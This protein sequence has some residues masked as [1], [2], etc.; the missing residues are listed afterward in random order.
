MSVI[1]WIERDVIHRNGHYFNSRSVRGLRGYIFV[2][3]RTVSKKSRNS[4]ILSN[5][6][7]G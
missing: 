7:I 4:S 2:V 1:I 6:I 3:Y 5:N